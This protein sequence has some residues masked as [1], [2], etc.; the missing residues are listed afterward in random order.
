MNDKFTWP[1]VARQRRQQLLATTDMTFKTIAETLSKE[2]KCTLSR[3][4]IAGEKRRLGMAQ[5]AKL[6][7]VRAKKMKKIRVDA[8]IVPEPPRRD[9]RPFTLLI[10]D[11]DH[12][13]CHWP[14][15]EAWQRPPFFYC[16]EAAVTG[17]P[18]CETHMRKSVSNWVKS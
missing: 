13:V 4:A 17:R 7:K 5:M 11:L 14:S 15:G 9:P 18:Y 3:S 6:P 16:G 1:L 2:F 8:P 10:T 12:S